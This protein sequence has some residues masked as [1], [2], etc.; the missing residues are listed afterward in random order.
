MLEP[1]EY[2]KI[3][4]NMSI[5]ELIDKKN[6]LITSIKEYEDNYITGN[7]KINSNINPSLPVRYKYHNLYLKEIIDIIL[8][9]N[10]KG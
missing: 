6:S 9:K 10:Y 1:S 2:K 7:K 4:E 8:T 5:E 3:Y